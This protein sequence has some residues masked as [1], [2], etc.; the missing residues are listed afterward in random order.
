MR[1]K[2]NTNPTIL[3]GLNNKINK[4]TYTQIRYQ[5]LMTEYYFE[6]SER[7]NYNFGYWIAHLFRLEYND[8]QG[9]SNVNNPVQS[10][11]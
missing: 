10:A 4:S 3:K 7:I 5:C 6:V 1:G 8:P 9:G 2:K 11:G